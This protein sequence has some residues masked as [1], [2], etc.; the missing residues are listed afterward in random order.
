M[1]NLSWDK[2]SREIEKNKANQNEYAA[3]LDIYRDVSKIQF[4]YGEKINVPF[5]F[6]EEE[7]L[8]KYFRQGNYLLSGDSLE[9]DWEMFREMMQR[10]AKVF[11]KDDQEAEGKI[12]EL[13]ALEALKE[14]NLKPLIR[15]K[16]GITPES[17]EKHLIDSGVKEHCRIEPEVIVDICF[18]AL[19][20]FYMDYAR[21]AAEKNDFHL[22]TNGFCPVCGQKPMMAKLSR[23]N[24]ARVMECWLC[25]AEWKFPRLE[26]PYCNN[27]DHEKLGYF[28]AD[29]EKARRVNV[30]ERCKSYLKA[31]NLKEIGK[32]VILDL[33]NILTLHLDNEAQEKGYKPGQDLSLLN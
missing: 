10:I 3:I 19:S 22:W 21:K 9:I 18:S 20:P 7:E 4:G 33:E 12:E 26:C 27:R 11:L 29:E 28:F 23:E 24:S 15:E 8:K 2:L 5:N 13:T 32:E 16:G 17:L 30:C 25:H 14:E 1:Q 31:V 6:K